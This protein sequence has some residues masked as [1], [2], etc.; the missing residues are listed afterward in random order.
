[1]FWGPLYT[2]CSFLGLI[3]KFGTREINDY[4]KSVLILSIHSILKRAWS[5]SLSLFHSYKV[6]KHN[7]DLEL[8]NL[9]RPLTYLFTSGA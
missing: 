9:N 2:L 5:L 3:Q 1:M 4:S 6:S 8:E 7:N